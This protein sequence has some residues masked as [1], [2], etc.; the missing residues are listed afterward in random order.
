MDLVTEGNMQLLT[1]HSWTKAGSVLKVIPQAGLQYQ[2]YPEEW[3][4]RTILD[5][6]PI[7]LKHSLFITTIVHV[8]V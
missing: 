2:T 3:R 8:H 7:E 4:A 1:E 6:E 5:I